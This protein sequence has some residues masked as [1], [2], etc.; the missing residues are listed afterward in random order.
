[1]KKPQQTTAI[2]SLDPMEWAIDPAADPVIVETAAPVV[3][4]AVNSSLGSDV[5][6]PER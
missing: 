4:V 1:M 6:S 3:P 2:A 5:D